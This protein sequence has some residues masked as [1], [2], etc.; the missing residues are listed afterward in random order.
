MLIKR[1]FEVT[2]PTD[3]V[4]KLLND[5]PKVAPCLPGADLIEIVDHD[6]YK[7][8]VLGPMSLRFTGTARVVERNQAARRIVVEANGSEDKGAS[9]ASMSIAATVVSTRRGSRVV[10]AQDLTLLGAAAQFGRGA[11]VDVSAVLVRAFAANLQHTIDRENGG[12]APLARHAAP[13]VRHVNLAF[14]ALLF[15]LGQLLRRLF[16]RSD[17][18][19]T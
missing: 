12:P 13:P 3:E 8:R 16:G 6:T 14:S 4:W 19:R 9:Q 7:G 11:V 10:V 15:G 2:A 1:E 17:V 5:I 18:R